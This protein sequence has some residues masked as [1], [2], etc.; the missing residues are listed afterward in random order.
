MVRQTMLDHSGSSPKRHISERMGEWTNSAPHC[1]RTG[2]GHPDDSCLV[3]WPVA[4]QIAHPAIHTA[5]GVS[6]A[7]KKLIM[8][9]HVIISLNANIIN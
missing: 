7:V 1:S 4:S 6:N 2:C 9:T 3:P 8:Q 5:M